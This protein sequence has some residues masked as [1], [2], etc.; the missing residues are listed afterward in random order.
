M[1]AESRD[2]ADQRPDDDWRYDGARDAV[3][4]AKQ[5]RED[6]RHAQDVSR[7]LRQ[8]GLLRRALTK[9]GLSR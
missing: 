3:D 1:T 9:L 2:R 6:A 5:T 7:N 4:R 8:A